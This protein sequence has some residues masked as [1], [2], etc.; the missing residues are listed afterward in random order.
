[1]ITSY[2][3]CVNRTLISIGRLSGVCHDTLTFMEKIRIATRKSALA[4][5]QAHWIADL[6]RIHHALTIEFVSLKAAS[7]QALPA[8]A[9]VGTSSLRR[10]SQVKALRPD[11]QTCL[12]RGNVDTR[13]NKLMA[14][15]YDAIILAACGL[16]RLNL[17]GQIRGLF[18]P[19]E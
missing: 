8:G 19:T 18:P 11:L 16:E 5:W 15:Q 12:L 6:L 4:Q 1:M 10:Q 14:G 7:F 13:V 9:T 3:A 17:G 2:V